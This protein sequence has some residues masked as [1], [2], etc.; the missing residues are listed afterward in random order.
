MH[1]I[2]LKTAEKIKKIIFGLTVVFVMLCFAINKSYSQTEQDN[3]IK[4]WNDYLDSAYAYIWL[5]KDQLQD[6]I[7]QRE[8]ENEKSLN[9][10]RSESGQRLESR[11]AD[12]TASDGKWDN[13]DIMYR[14][15]AIA[16]AIISLNSESG[17]ELAKAVEMIDR[18]KKNEGI[19]ENIYWINYIH[20]LKE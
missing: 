6:Y 18:I 3:K 5:P 13:R 16:H 12:N 17:E 7:A 11:N 8:K 4:F 1:I 14:R 2:A 10:Y 19:P 20:A 15:L 9:E